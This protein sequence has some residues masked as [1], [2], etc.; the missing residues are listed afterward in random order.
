MSTKKIQN[1]GY[2][3][4]FRNPL[5]EIHDGK[6]MQRIMVMS[7]KVEA[8]EELSKHLPLKSVFLVP[9]DLESL[10]GKYMGEHSHR[11]IARMNSSFNKMDGVMTIDLSSNSFEVYVYDEKD[12][13]LGIEC[14]SLFAEVD[15]IS[16]EEVKEGILKHGCYLGC[17]S[18]VHHG[19]SHPIQELK[20]LV[21]VDIYPPKEEQE[22]E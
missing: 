15:T 14:R 7:D 20:K 4:M 10:E 2:S 5:V 21:A 8:V 6:V 9:K 13:I 16:D 17:R 18:I 22:D 3:G 12:K 11:V 1:A 19:G